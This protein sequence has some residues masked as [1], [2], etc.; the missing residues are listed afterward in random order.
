LKTILLYYLLPVTDFAVCFI[1]GR[2][3]RMVLKYFSSIKN[4]KLFSY[5]R[6]MAAPYSR[7]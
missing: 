2:L 3:L 1:S 5:I 4:R 6:Q 7:L